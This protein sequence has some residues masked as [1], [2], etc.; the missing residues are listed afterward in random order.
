MASLEK[1]GKKYRIIF[2]VH[3]QRHYVSLRTAKL[4]QAEKFQ[5]RLEANLADVLAG[6]LS[7]PPDA[8]VGTFLLSNGKATMQPTITRSLSLS[9]FFT[10]Y[11]ASQRTKEPNTLYTEDIHI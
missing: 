11:Q 8:D 10:T 6:S 4:D 2:C 7:I 9:E 5:K 1:R 3:G